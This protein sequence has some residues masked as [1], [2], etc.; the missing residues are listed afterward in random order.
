MLCRFEAAAEFRSGSVEEDLRHPSLDDGI[1]M[2]D[3]AAASLAFQPGFVRHNGA[4][5]FQLSLIDFCDAHAKR[6][7]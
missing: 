2:F 7:G 4:D 6:V 5:D 3:R 1:T